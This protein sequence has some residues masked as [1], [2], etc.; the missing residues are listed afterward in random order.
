THMTA[1]FAASSTAEITASAS[2]SAAG[3][4]PNTFSGRG[5]VG[6][7]GVDDDAVGAVA[8]DRFAAAGDQP[9]FGVAGAG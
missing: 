3:Q 8:V 5:A 7:V 4:L 6:Q 2:Q 1:I 9:R